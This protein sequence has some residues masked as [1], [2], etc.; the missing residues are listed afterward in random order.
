MKNQFIVVLCIVFVLPTLIGAQEKADLQMVGKIK[1]EGFN[2]SQVMDIVSFLTDVHGP[3][4]TGSPNM[5]AAG[6]W[7]RDKLKEWGLVNAQL[8]SW[9]AFGRGWAVEKFSLEMLEPQYAPLIA[10]PE[11]WT[12]G[13]EGT[14]TGTPVYAK[15]ESEADL[16]KYK[17]KLRGAIVLARPPVSAKFHSDPEG[18]RFDEKELAEMAMAE[19]PGATPEFMARREEFRRQRELR[20]KAM[21]FFKEEG[22][23]VL[24]SPSRIGDYGTIFVGGGGSRNLGA[25]LGLPSAIVAIEH[26]GRLVRIIEKGI[27]LKV[28]IN[29]QNKFY[30]A[31][32][33]GYNTVAEIP[34]TDKKLKDEVVMLGGHLDS[35][36]PGTGATDNAA[37]CAVAME[38]VRILKA[39]ELQPRRTIRIALWSGEEQG[40]LGS[41]G[42]VQK[43]FGDPKTMKLTSE[44]ER[45]SSY[46]NLDHG[47]GKIRGVYLQGN[48]AVRPIFEAW[49]KPFNDLG[50]N[51]MTIRNTG[52][53]DHLAFDAIGLPGFQFIQDEIEYETRTHHSN[54][55]VYDHLQAGDLMQASVIMASFV[56][57]AA[58]RDEKLPRKEPPKPQPPASTTTMR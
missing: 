13:T 25:P 34:G 45:F 53:T 20:D 32:S 37:G 41:R 51:T 24:L 16:E 57:H 5:K 36:H 23:A 42:Y 35:W 46:F 43:H 33:L 17:G 6:E 38:A 39:L 12:P 7:A 31:D 2:N 10:H 44:H 9:G 47:T 50:A 28:S 29:I 21:K 55:D 58:M 15:I 8:E 1:T 49:L 52:G 56:Y 19:T 4:L 27:P 11:A 18:E 30:E 14:M 3:R 54:M 22:A 40:L 48:D 26:Y